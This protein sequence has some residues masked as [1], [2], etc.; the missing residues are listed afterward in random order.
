[1]HGQLIKVFGLSTLLALS[2]NRGLTQELSPIPVFDVAS[3][4]PC[5]PGT[6]APAGQ[7]HGMVRFTFPG[8]RFQ[9][10]AVT[11]EFLLEWAYDV[12]PLQH[13]GGPSW[14]DSSRYD[15]V[16]KASGE[17]S[18][19]QIKRMVQALLA[20]RFQLKFHREA[21]SLPA[22]IISQG[23][24]APKLFV[25]K[26]GEPRSLKPTPQTDTD[27]KISSWHVVATRY[28][29][30]DLTNVFARQLGRVIVNKTGLQGDFDFTLDL[31]P[32]ES[33]P[34]PLDPSLL[35]SAMRQQLGLALKSENAPVD[36]LV[37][38]SAQKAVVEN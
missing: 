20:D 37:I 14:M 22:L 4:K 36:F 30:A 21:R 26:E 24:E 25:P 16:A 18:D 31:T 32:D 13:S 6:P 19:A 15:V 29:L 2:W 10:D 35:I 12:L 11:L 23:K 3:V 1:M 38:D 7:D 34:N 9:A 17:A 33:R 28:S 5:A 8:G 27:G